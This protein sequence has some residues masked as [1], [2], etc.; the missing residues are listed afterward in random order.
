MQTCTPLPVAG[1]TYRAWRV[2]FVL[3]VTW[4]LSAAALSVNESIQT[5]VAALRAEPAKD[6][7]EMAAATVVPALYDRHDY[8][9]VWSNPLS[10]HQ[11]VQAIARCDADG[12]N[13]A[14][15]HLDTIRRLLERNQET[16]LSNPERT[17]Y[18]DL[19]LTDALVRLGYHLAFGK[20]DPHT[21]DT[22][23]SMPGPGTDLKALLLSSPAITSG[24]IDALL[25]SL[26]PHS[27]RYGQ[28]QQALAQYRAYRDR[29]GWQPVAAGPALKPGMTEARVPAL[30]ARLAVTGDLATGEPQSMDYDESLSTAVRHFQRRHGL[31][32]DGVTGDRTL[33]EL[34]VPVEARI[35]QIRANLERARWIPHD[36]PDDFIQV[37]IAGYTVRLVQG[38]RVVWETRAIVGQPVRQSPVLHSTL[39]RLE[40]NPSWTVPPVVLARDVLPELRRNPGYLQE[41]HMQVIDFQ[42]NPVDTTGVDWSRYRAYNFPWMIRQQPG[43]QNALGRVKFLFPNT[44]SVYLHDTPVKALFRQ[45]ERAFS[46]GC[47]RVE[48]PLELAERLLQHN[49]GWDHKRL[50]HALESSVTHSVS[51]SRP[52][53][54]FLMYWTVEVADDGTVQFH[55][56]IYGRDPALVQALDQPPDTRPPEPARPEPAMTARR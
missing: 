43:P 22:D 34:N 7:V 17:A 11:L 20:V 56:D 32:A 27:A 6:P 38:R 33:A 36:L 48:H 28:L 23:W 41:K 14:D 39:S 40:I 15:Y 10:V 13:P 31:E 46:S 16:G 50:L 37:D 19:L 55:D 12:L 45:P 2:A 21:L 25:Q 24:R 26:R 5:Q 35:E 29:G 8:A 1:T 53:D 4:P 52:I 30:R 42:G 44:H 49:A 18:L 51:L 3:L 47:I 9:P 54:I